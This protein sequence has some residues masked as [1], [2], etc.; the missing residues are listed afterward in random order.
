MS[1]SSCQYYIGYPVGYSEGE[2][3]Y[4][5]APACAEEPPCQFYSPRNVVEQP[6]PRLKANI[7]VHRH[8]PKK[9]KCHN[10]KLRDSVNEMLE[11]A[12]SLAGGVIDDVVRQEYREGD[13]IEDMTEVHLCNAIAH[14][15]I[16]FG[17]RRDSD[18]LA[19]ALCCL[20]LA[21]ASD[22]EGK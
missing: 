5:K 14:I 8:S 15:Y 19:R 11:Q 2:C 18:H 17:G 22:G 16:W 7:T 12:N 6:K 4:R 1:C 10:V 20:A 21:A 9:V 13:A 3:L